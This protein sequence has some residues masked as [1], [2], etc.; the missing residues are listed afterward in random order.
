MSQTFAGLFSCA[1]CCEETHQFQKEC[2]CKHCSKTCI[3][4]CKHCKSAEH[5]ALNNN[6]PE[7]KKQQQFK[8]IMITQKLTFIEAKTQIENRVNDD[9]KNTYASITSLTS[10]M[11]NLR[12]EL[13]N[14]KELNAKLIERIT[15]AEKIIFAFPDVDE[16]K[17]RTDLI[18]DSNNASTSIATDLIQIKPMTNTI[19]DYKLKY[20][21][22]A[23]CN[24]KQNH[25]L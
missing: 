15:S 14:I 21:I 9:N 4:L 23:T 1:N 19:R 13:D 2:N 17:D 8:K 24:N 25:K 10:Q 20:K 7:N 12:R 5:N 11:D 3:Q 18:N 16:G 6:C 22:Q